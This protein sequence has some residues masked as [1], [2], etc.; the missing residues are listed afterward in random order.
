MV[1]AVVMILPLTV[2]EHVVVI[3]LKTVPVLV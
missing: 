3:L 2:L 1:M